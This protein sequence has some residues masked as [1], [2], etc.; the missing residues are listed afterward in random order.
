MKRSSSWRKVVTVVVLLAASA[1]AQMGNPTGQDIQSPILADVRIDQKLNQQV[2]LDLTFQDESGRTVPLGT[3]FGKKPVILTLVYYQCPM[4]CTQVLN[5]MTSTLKTLTFDAGKDFEVVA[6]S[7]DP[8]ETPQMAAEK[9]AVYLKEYN[10]PGDD[11]G[12]HFLVGNQQ[13][14]SAL[15]DAVGFRYAWDARTQQ[16]AH[17][18]AIMVLTPGGKLA[19]YFYG[20]EYSPRD[21]RFGLVQASQGRIGTLVDS[22]LLYCYHY[23]PTAGKYGLV[24]T[25]A[26]QLGAGATLLILGGFLIIMF[27]ADIKKPKLTK[28]DL[29]AVTTGRAR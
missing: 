14:I 3:Y 20:I 27:K 17:A 8:R 2:P 7:I 13:N 16:Y 15:A 4:L 6:V 25:R 5:G 29:N 19:Q 22:V 28:D 24:V 21:V 12:W 11:Q 26:L 10:R 9:K 18:T 23:D 1:L